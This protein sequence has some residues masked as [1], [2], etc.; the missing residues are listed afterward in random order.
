[1]TGATAGPADSQARAGAASRAG[2]PARLRGRAEWAD[3]L[4]LLYLLVFAR[5][6]LWALDSNALGWALSA[7]LAAGACY[8][9]VR[10][11]PFAAE[12]AGREFWL[13]VV[14]ALVFFYALRLPF[15]DISYDV[16]NYRLLHAERSLR[17]A[18]FAPGDYFPTP[19]PYN[20]APDT[21]TGLFRHALGYRL[22]TVVNLFALVWAA[23]VADNLLRPFVSKAWP[24]A[25]CVLL[26]ALAEHLLFEVNNY[27]VD[28]LSL[29]LLLEATRLALR[30]A[31]AEGRRALLAHAALL[32]GLAA[33]LKLTN[34]AAVLTIVLLCAYKALSGARRLKLRELPS[35]LALSALAFAAP[36][37]PFTVYLW[38]VT[39][40][41][42]FPLAN[43]FFRSPYWHTEG[44]WDG[45]WGPRAFWE[46]P[47]W[48][49]LAWAEP[50]RHSELGVYSG[51][52]ALGFVV[53]L[54]GLLLARRDR[55]ARELCLTLL[56]GCLAWS[57]GGMGY[58]RY[59]LYLE[60]LAGVC[61]VAVAAAVL[62]A[63]QADQPATHAPGPADAAAPR[64]RLSWRTAACALLVAALCAQAAAACV[65]ALGH[66]WSMRPTAF[67]DWGAFRHEARYILRDR[68]LTDFFD[69]PTRALAAGVGA[70]VNSATKSNGVEALIRPDAPVVGVNHG[71]FFSTRAGRREFARAAE[72]APAPVYTLCQ[73]EELG[74]ARRH[75]ESRGLAVGRVTAL[76]VPFFSQRRR[77]GMMLVEV[78]R[79]AGGEALA[80]FWQSAAYPDE[81][82]RAEV[83]AAAEPPRSMRAGERA[84]LRVR[85]SNRGGFVWPARGD[86]GGRFPVTLGDRWMDAAATKVVNDLDGRASLAAD[87]PPGGGAELTLP[88]K[89][90]ER[91]GEYV[92]ELDM[93]HEGVTFFHAKGSPTLRLKVSVGP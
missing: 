37:A 60:A 52:V 19:A 24:R 35:A 9:Y 27:M 14:P 71:E 91:P 90:P 4:V 83:A 69:A 48:P 16:L 23:R 62:R 42:L 54:C 87:L 38:R 40:N 79:P 15:P 29:P 13:L 47:V 84:V 49:V 39:G 12:R 63:G 22:G 36:L 8:L 32:L 82:Y 68:R 67:S 25:A 18:L 76:E 58:S 81:D 70:W 89:A 2:A 3:A 86:A 7:P 21:V 61:V 74:Q 65:Y 43:G 6:Y 77:I 46:T 17:G 93:I 50:A 55:R 72:S 1:M 57:A 45:R 26:V 11:K 31:E 75:V 44:G 53:A 64:A 10:T 41:P 30:Y 33:A 78:V 88:V 5:Q 80:A 73:P 28:L 51:R 85:V 20:P 92:L 34:A 56:V 59:G 66:E